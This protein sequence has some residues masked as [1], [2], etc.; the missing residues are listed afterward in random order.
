MPS[1]ETCDMLVWSHLTN[2]WSHL[3]DGVEWGGGELHSAGTFFP[4]E[5][6]SSRIKSH[7]YLPLLFSLSFHFLGF[8]S[9]LVSIAGQLD[10]IGKAFFSFLIRSSNLSPARA[11]KTDLVSVKMVT[12][13]H[14]PHMSLALSMPHT[15]AF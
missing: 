14:S 13:W 15:R 10:D 6:L 2:V 9:K 8:C 11:S 5:S 4:L 1:A 7:W 3:F 12:C